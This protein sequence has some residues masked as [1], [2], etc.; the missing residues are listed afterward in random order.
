VGFKGVCF[1]GRSGSDCPIRTGNVFRWWAMTDRMLAQ[2]NYA[3]TFE[4]LLI[5][6]SYLK[7]AKTQ[8]LL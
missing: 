7:M 3:A 6:H 4:L 8:Y 5:R 2:T 1:G